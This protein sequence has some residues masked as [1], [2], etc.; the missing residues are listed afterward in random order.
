MYLVAKDGKVA[1]APVHFGRIKVYLHAVLTSLLNRLIAL[2]RSCFATNLPVSDIDGS[3]FMVHIGPYTVENCTSHKYGPD[4][5]PCWQQ[6]NNVYR[7]NCLSLGISAGAVAPQSREVA[8]ARL[9]V[10]ITT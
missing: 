8:R 7:L 9:V 6:F 3:E 10:T 4:I 5:E 1:D 2:Y